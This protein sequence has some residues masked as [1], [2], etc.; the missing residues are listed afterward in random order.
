MVYLSFGDFIKS[1]SFRTINTLVTSNTD[2]QKRKWVD[3]K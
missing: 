2:L 1:S 3:S